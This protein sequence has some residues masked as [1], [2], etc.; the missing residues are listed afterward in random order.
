MQQHAARLFIRHCHGRQ[1]MGG[2]EAHTIAP[3]DQGHFGHVGRP[4]RGKLRVARRTPQ[5]RQPPAKIVQL[6]VKQP[7]RSARICFREEQPLADAAVFCD[8]GKIPGSFAPQ[9]RRLEPWRHIGQGLIRFVPDGMQRLP[10]KQIE[11]D[12]REAFRPQRIEMGA[13]R[14]QGIRGVTAGKHQQLVGVKHQHP[15]A[16]SEAVEHG[17]QPIDPKVEAA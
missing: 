4:A 7:Q 8:I 15:M 11:H 5:E 16:T 10:R 2:D 17:V 13:E 12:D 3:A 14:G 6:L 9:P 1:R